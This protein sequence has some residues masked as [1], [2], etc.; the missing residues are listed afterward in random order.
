[1][2]TVTRFGPKVGQIGPKWDKSGKFSYQ[3]QYI[4]ANLTHFGAKSGNRDVRFGP[5]KGKIG[6]KM[7]QVWDFSNSDFCTF[8]LVDKKKY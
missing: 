5:I 2:N 8:W 6:T 7:G 3:I 4:L 1:M